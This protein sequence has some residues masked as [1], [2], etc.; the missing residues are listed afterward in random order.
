MK[1]VGATLLL[2]LFTEL[3]CIAQ[4]SIYKLQDD[5]LCG[6][7]KP[8]QAS[9]Y[10]IAYSTNQ[11]VYSVFKDKETLWQQEW[12]HFTSMLQDSIRALHLNLN[13]GSSIDHRIYFDRSGSIAIYY[14][15]LHQ[16]D[17]HQEHQ[18]DT[19]IRNFLEHYH[20]KLEA[21]TNY[22]YYGTLRFQ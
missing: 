8:A 3:S 9:G 6:V 10:M 5:Q 13:P 17:E 12:H 4:L 14:Y 19:A 11:Q 16:F 22:W 2:I 20:M 7:D 15:T 1:T 21:G 18:F